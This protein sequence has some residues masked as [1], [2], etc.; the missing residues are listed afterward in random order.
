MPVARLDSEENSSHPIKA[1]FS[2]PKARTPVIPYDQRSFCAHGCSLSRSIAQ[3]VS[4]ICTMT[5]RA[6]TGASVP[7]TTQNV[8]WY[9]TAAVPH[10]P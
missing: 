4:P 8:S 9:A 7:V 1:R 6:T 5:A 2:T 3:K 10:A